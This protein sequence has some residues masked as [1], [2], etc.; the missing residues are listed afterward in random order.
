MS[1]VQQ[2]YIR[3]DGV[4]HGPASA[5]DLKVLLEAKRITLQ[6]EAGPAQEGP[7]RPLSSYPEFAPVRPISE[8]FG[9]EPVSQAPRPISDL[10]PSTKTEPLAPHHLPPRAGSSPTG[11]IEEVRF[12]KLKLNKLS[13]VGC[14][15]GLVIVAFV[16]FGLILSARIFGQIIGLVALIS[17]LTTA[18]VFIVFR[19]KKDPL[20]IG[21]DY[22]AFEGKKIYARDVVKVEVKEQRDSVLLSIWTNHGYKIINLLD[23]G[24]K[25][26]GVGEVADI[27]ARRLKTRTG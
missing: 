27:I 5:A 19:W 7:W 4:I 8:L 24:I 6:Q 17:C 1:N 11:E 3:K 26:D 2:W 10:L 18:V 21:E 20:V 15:A 25:P 22:I 13:V 9:T 14:G 16:A 12:E 23:Y